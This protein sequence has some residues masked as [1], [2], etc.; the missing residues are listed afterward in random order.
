LLNVPVKSARYAGKRIEQTFED[1]M[2]ALEKA[3]KQPMGPPREIQKVM[4]EIQGK[5]HL[6]QLR[7]QVDR[8][9]ELEEGCD[10]LPGGG[11]RG[12]SA[13][14][15]RSVPALAAGLRRPGALAFPEAAVLAGQRLPAR[16]R[17]VPFRALAPEV[18]L[19]RVPLELEEERQDLGVGHLGRGLARR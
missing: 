13:S 11:A 12:A 6:E 15:G 19:V 3:A 14:P 16:V 4:A 17:A 1:A 8:H 10:I 9:Q 2:E 18:A 7:A 5:Q